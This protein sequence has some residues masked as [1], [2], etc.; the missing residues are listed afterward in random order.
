V[1]RIEKI[2]ARMSP[3]MPVSDLIPESKRIGQDHAPE[4][5]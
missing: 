2:D 5:C 4:K 1:N 3:K